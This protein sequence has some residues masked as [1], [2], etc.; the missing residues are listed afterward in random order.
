MKQWEYIRNRGFCAGF[1]PRSFVRSAAWVLLGAVL[2]LAG[3]SKDLAEGPAVGESEI[4]VSASLPASLEAEFSTKAPVDGSA[5]M[6]L[7]FARSDESSTGVWGGYGTTV[8]N[9]SR[10]AGTGSRTLTFTTKQYYQRTGLKTRMMGWYPSA[11][12]YTSGVVNWTVNGTQDVLC[13]PS[14]EGSKTAAM[15]AFTFSHQLTQLQFFCYAEN[16]TAVAQ[17]GKI[18][19]IRVLGQRTVCSYT[20]STGAFAFS[21]S[22][23]SLS[24]PGITAATPPVGNALA[25]TQY[26]Q[27]LMIEPR[28]ADTQLFLEIDTERG[29]TLLLSL[30]VQAYKAGESAKVMLYFRMVG[31]NVGCILQQPWVQSDVTNANVGNDNANTTYPYMFGNR[32]RTIIVKDLSLIH[33]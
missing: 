13:A 21:G 12:S 7:Y 14:Q 26:G 20:L 25:A 18:T 27:A 10:A 5:Q 16:A 8:L 30:P 2:S 22:T 3:C 11:T 1:F 17:W 15:P 23:A 31:C 19:A 24:V 4:A 29:G 28:T 9:A 33:I 6:T 32:G